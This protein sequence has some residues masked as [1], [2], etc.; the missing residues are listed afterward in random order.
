[1]LGSSS[2]KE[3]SYFLLLT[4]LIPYLSFIALVLSLL[5]SYEIQFLISNAKVLNLPEKPMY[6]WLFMT[7]QTVAYQAP[8]SMGFSRQELL[9]WVAIS[10]GSSQPRD[11][12]CISCISC[13]GTLAVRLFTTLPPGKPAD[14]TPTHTHTHTHTHIA[15]EALWKCSLQNS[16]QGNGIENSFGFY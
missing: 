11:R 10:R 9:E 15:G 7:P 3:M 6:I 13:I 8:L 2:L 5:L 1:M 4:E 14:T 12:T 16:P